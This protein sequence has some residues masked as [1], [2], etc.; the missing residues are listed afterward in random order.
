MSKTQIIGIIIA[1]FLLIL[2][3]AFYRSCRETGDVPPG[4]SSQSQMHLE[5]TLHA[6]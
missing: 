6:A 5:S 1:I 3:I 2:L 4:G